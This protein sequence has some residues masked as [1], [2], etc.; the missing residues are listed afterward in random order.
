MLADQLIVQPGKVNAIFLFQVFVFLDANQYLH[1][2]IVEDIVKS[3]NTQN[4]IA[5]Y[6]YNHND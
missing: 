6:D 5:L 4:N 3:R 1:K 2:K